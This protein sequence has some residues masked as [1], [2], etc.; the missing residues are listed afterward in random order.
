MAATSGHRN[1]CLIFSKGRDFLGLPERLLASGS[2]L[3]RDK[4]F[5]PFS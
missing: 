1:K 2:I 4:G 5:L 3:C